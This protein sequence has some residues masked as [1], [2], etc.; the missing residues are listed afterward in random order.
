MGV[1]P[2]LFGVN[3]KYVQNICDETR[4][5]TS[6]LTSLGGAR[7]FLRR[8]GALCNAVPGKNLL[9]SRCVPKRV[10]KQNKCAVYQVVGLVDFGSNLAC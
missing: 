5:R 6:S 7:H 4:V 2:G 3:Q 1:G 8:V 9:P 10:R